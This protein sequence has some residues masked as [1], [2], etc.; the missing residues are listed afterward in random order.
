MLIVLME[1]R[2]GKENRCQS[3]VVPSS[4]CYHRVDSPIIRDEIPLDPLSL[5]PPLFTPSECHL[6]KLFLCSEFDGDPSRKNQSP[7]RVVVWE[8]ERESR[9]SI[10]ED[11]LRDS[12]P[13]ASFSLFQ[14]SLLFVLRLRSCY[15]SVSTPINTFTSGRYVESRR[16]A[17][18]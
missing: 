7:R 6:M 14:S 13:P 15:T 16:R 11:K 4:L 18:M 2:M 8:K 12:I 17:A 9:L 5:S 1:V 10:R 3:R